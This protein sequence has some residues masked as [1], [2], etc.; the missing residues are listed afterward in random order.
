MLFA[1]GWEDVSTRA[2]CFWSTG[3]VVFDR[4]RRRLL[5]QSLNLKADSEIS[6]DYLETRLFDALS[7]AGKVQ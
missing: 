3:V 6:V 7:T 1:F 4:D 2:V 5:S